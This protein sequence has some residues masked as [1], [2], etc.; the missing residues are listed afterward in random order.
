M[1]EYRTYGFM[2]NEKKNKGKYLPLVVRATVDKTGATLSI[3][4]EE[5]SG[6]QFTIDIDQILYDI[7]KEKIL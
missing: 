6:I 3:A 1:K 5:N 2:Y 7:R 4:D